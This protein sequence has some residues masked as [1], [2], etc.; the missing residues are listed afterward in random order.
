MV[1][2]SQ[3]AAV[4]PAL[5]TLYDVAPLDLLLRMKGERPVTT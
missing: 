5:P 3:S 2:G 4:R 1:R